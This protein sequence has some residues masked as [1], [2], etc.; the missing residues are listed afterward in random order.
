MKLLI[1]SDIH[2]SMPATTRLL[3]LAA[4]HQPTA[5]LL[6]GDILYHGPR[7]PPPE[8]YAPKEVAT[9]LSPLAKRIIAIKGNCD[10][11]VDAMVLPFPLASDFSWLLD[12]TSRIFVTHGHRYGPETLPPLEEGDVLL[13]GHTHT[14]MAHTTASG[15]H[16]CNPGSLSMPKEDHPACYGMFE[17]SVFSVFTVADE[18]Y[19]QL[20]C[21]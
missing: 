11:E 7:N 17:D 8:G 3:T 1:F 13:F 18:L 19:L 14:P 21:A 16:L 2:G 15:V 6:L 5:V 10:S 12:G 20:D 9:A 4:E